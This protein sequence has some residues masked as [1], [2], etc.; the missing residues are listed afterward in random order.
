MAGNKT[1]AAEGA[2]TVAKSLV[3]KA[4][5][6]RWEKAIAR[7][8]AA[9]DTESSG[10]DDRYEALGDIIESEPP[11]YLAGGHATTRAFLKAEAP[12]ETERSV[13][14]SIRVARHFE[15]SDEATH[16]IAKLEALLD[17]LAAH[18]SKATVPAKL[19]LAR[20]RVRVAE[21]KS[22]RMR[23]FA[24]LTLAELRRAARAK[25]AG[26]SEASAKVPAEVKKW[27]AAL[28]KAKLSQ[29]GVSLQGGL[30]TFSGIAPEMV[31]KVGAVLGKG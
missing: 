3:D 17:Y 27:R 25:G 4:L 6:A 10:W 5:K 23:P 9:R 11:Y 7:Y 16:G 1:A 20:Q 2:G 12:G 29:V 15:P 30:L 26:S 18:G 21:G 31:K 22:F 24:E 28:A 13:R 8:R 14:R 19:D